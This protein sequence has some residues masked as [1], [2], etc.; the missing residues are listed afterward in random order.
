MKISLINA[1][2][3]YVFKPKTIRIVI[4][5]AEELNALRSLCALNVYIPG[6]VQKG[7]IADDLRHFLDQLREAL[8]V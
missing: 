1:A 3:P 8:Y 2:E 4:E 5:S 6:L 7:F